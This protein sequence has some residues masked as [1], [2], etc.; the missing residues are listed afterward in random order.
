MIRRNADISAYA[1]P[2]NSIG[3]ANDELLE[4][5]RILI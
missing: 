5:E 4:F 3:K 2:V 1:K